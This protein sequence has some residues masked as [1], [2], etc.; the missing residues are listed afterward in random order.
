[1]L[2]ALTDFESRARMRSEHGL[3]IEQ[4]CVVWSRAIDGLLPPA[5]AVS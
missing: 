3:G 5:P 1:M 2:E 4:A